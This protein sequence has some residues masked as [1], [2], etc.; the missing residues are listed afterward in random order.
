MKQISQYKFSKVYDY[1][2]PNDI[3]RLGEKR[4]LTDDLYI[5]RGSHKS[6]NYNYRSDGSAGLEFK[7]TPC[8]KLMSLSYNQYREENGE[9]QMCIAAWSC[10]DSDR[11]LHKFRSCLLYTSP[12]PRD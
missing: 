6:S 11:R 2:D 10:Q 3:V 4:F 8:L 5:I 12:S 7:F 1:S 9:Y